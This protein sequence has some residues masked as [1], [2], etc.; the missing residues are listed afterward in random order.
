MKMKVLC[1]LIYGVLISDI[2]MSLVT[3]LEIFGRASLFF[4]WS[5]IAIIFL[6]FI[7]LCVDPSAV[8]EPSE[9]TL[10]IAV[11][12]RVIVLVLMVIVSK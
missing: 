7:R 9:P 6:N 1:C 2:S 11:I 8:D 10:K 5:T 12:F 4:I 3:D